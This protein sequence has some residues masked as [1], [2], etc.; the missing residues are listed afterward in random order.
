MWP[1]DALPW[2]LAA[3]RRL[4]TTAPA[5]PVLACIHPVS[6]LLLSRWLPAGGG[7]MVF[8]YQ[9]SV[10]PFRRQ[11]PYEYLP[12][13]RM[14]GWL[15][16]LERSAL[17]RADGAVFTSDVNREAYVG[18]GLIDPSRSRYIPHACDPNPHAGARLSCGERLVISHVGYFNQD[19]SPEV[20]LRGLAAFLKRRPEAANRVRVDLYGNGLGPHR[21]LCADLGLVPVVCECGETDYEVCLGA[22]ANS[23]LLLLVAA[24]CHRLFFPSKL[25]E[26]IAARRP[27]L[28]LLPVDSDARPILRAS[29]R[30]A[31]VCTHD[32][33]DQVTECLE[34]AWA[35]YVAGDLGAPLADYAGVLFERSVDAWMEALSA[36]SRS[37]GHRK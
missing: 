20:F 26:Y 25:P 37:D 34:T 15:A 7:G 10:T 14:V 11:V 13:R 2:T 28:A 17:R 19:R 21:G 8:D 36:F 5:G 22:I 16:R 31:R 29:G 6:S 18:E 4:K 12:H 1:D 3:A 33:P 32:A 9:E 30:D 27:V 23:H 35:A 24:P